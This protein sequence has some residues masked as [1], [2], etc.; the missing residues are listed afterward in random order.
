MNIEE[1][2]K[3]GVKKVDVKSKK[4]ISPKTKKVYEYDKEKYKGKYK[5]TS[6]KIYVKKRD[7]MS[8]E[9]KEKLKEYKKNYYQN[10]KE[11]YKERTK[12]GNERI[13]KAL[14]LLKEKEMEQKQ[15][16]EFV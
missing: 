16:V 9:D 1:D 11:Q 12:K 13:K 8:Q 14:K 7:A 5:E 6:H 10:N 2:K 3:N 4:V 15:K